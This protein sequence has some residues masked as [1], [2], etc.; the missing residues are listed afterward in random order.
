MT[1]WLP[2]PPELN[3]NPELATLAILDCALDVTCHAIY[4][5]CPDIH[6]SRAIL[7]QD[8]PL[9][10]LIVA[11]EIL[12]LSERLQESIYWYKQRLEEEEENKY[13]DLPF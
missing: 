2:I 5:V 12:S 6:D 13:K 11:R 7:G 3:T 1:K 10:S 4:A 8:K 9:M